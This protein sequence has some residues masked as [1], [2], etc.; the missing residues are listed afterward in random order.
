MTPEH[1]LQVKQIFQSAVEC[2]PDDRAAFLDKTCAG[3]AELRSE[4]ESLISSHDQAG[5]SLEAMAAGVAA[6]ML[7][8][9]QSAS[10][11]GRNVGPYSVIGLIG[12]GGVGEVY[13]AE[14]P[15]LGRRV[16]LKLLRREFAQDEERLRRFQQEAHAAS[17]LNHPNILTIHEIG[18]ADSRY[19]MATEYIEGE[20][21]R[22]HMSRTRMKLR[23]VLDVAMQVAGALAA[24]H[25]A[26][27]IHRDIKP[28][29]I[30]VRTDGYV[31]VLD[32]GLAKLTEQQINGD[33][34]SPSVSLVETSSGVLLGT[35]NYMSPEQA[36]GRPL[37]HRTD[38][39]S[40][41]V[42]LYEMLTGKRPFEGN[43]AVATLHAIINEEPPRADK[44]NSQLP[45]EATDI[46]AKAMG[47]NP[48]ERYQH[49][50]DFELDLLRLKRGIETNSLPSAQGRAI[51]P[52]GWRVA[53]MWVGLGALIILG[54][55]GAA[56]RL[57]RSSMGIPSLQTAH[58]VSLN[59]VTLAPLTL[60]PG[61]EGEPTLSADG[62]TIAYV[63]DRTG[64]FDI[65]L[66]QIS[67][68]PDIN[69]TNHPADDMQPAFSPDGKEI[70]FVSSRSGEVQCLCFFVYGTEQPLIGGGIWVMTTFG[71]SPRRI[72]ESGTFPS[73]SP[74]GS[75][76]I[77][78]HGP[79]FG[80]KIYRIASTGGDPQEISIHLKEEAP[81]LAYPSYSPNGR[82]IV[83][84]AINNIY[85]VKAGG[86]EPQNIIRGKHPVWSADSS[87][88]F[89][90]NV[91]AGKNYSL[92]QVPFSTMEGKVSGEASPLTVGRGYD[93]QPAVSRDGK[94]M[95]YTALDVSLNVEALPFD[96][97]AGRILGEPEPITR[98]NDRIYFFG[99][100]PDGRS[101]VFE[102]HRGASSHLWQVERGAPP[103]QL[104]SDP[105]FTDN[106]PRWSP[107]GRNIAFDRLVSKKE[108]GTSGLWLMAAD[109]GNPR[110]VIENGDLVGWMPDGSALVY[111]SDKD[112]QIYLYDL[113]KKSSRRITH[114]KGVA[115]G[116][117]PS[118]DGKW[119][120]YQSIG[121]G[122]VD[123]RAVATE[124]GESRTI[125]DAPRQKF[126]PFLS[127]S[128]RWLY[129]TLDHKNLYRVPGPALSWRKNKPERVTN[130]PETGLFLE[131]AQISH[132]GRQLFYSRRRVTG[133][134]WLMHLGN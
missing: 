35:V 98:G 132:N 117:G 26:G 107:D 13:L 71:G 54:I 11:I 53:R 8:E 128:G 52:H 90:S 47:K 41:G 125:V 48:Q 66:K 50:G 113:A 33:T 94:L 19:F 91:E 118:P 114:E 22:Q 9:D 12:K 44:L 42:V 63:S 49:A 61:Y 74:D 76:L 87:T 101:V 64:N 84:E 7:E 81:F 16:A 126:H 18:Q 23:E 99:V 109:G 85:V 67:G 124:T 112:G 29:N 58:T 121:S 21:L 70:A 92:W 79:W 93:A 30:M 78:S 106:Y 102:S 5:D 127:P 131:D 111:I 75:S 40:L 2:P 77:Y 17:A 120:V 46:L 104:T 10:F 32:F 115:G 110:L 108:L 55:A 65:F 72:V 119:I 89:Y 45:P 62:R 38:I 95:A 15:R 27:I 31:K 103:I 97:E 122:I 69:L 51:A 59:R 56:W 25:Q 123:V 73:W 4:V 134:I 20:T 82:W 24:A 6:Q 60:D 37:D 36:E 3:N 39:F 116:G 105:N 14:D 57:G 133:D 86:G 68:G 83:F 1:W 34:E 129:Y 88:I 43:S 80:Q 28:E 96:A 100:S 130:F